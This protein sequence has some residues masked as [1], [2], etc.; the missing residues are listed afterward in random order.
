MTDA[1]K[2]PAK[3]ELK[4][5]KCANPIEYDGKSYATGSTIKVDP[6][7]AKNLLRLGAIVELTPKAEA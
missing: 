7:T 5:Y 6:D 3:V 1:A 4:S 2:V